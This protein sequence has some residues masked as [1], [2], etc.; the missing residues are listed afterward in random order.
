MELHQRLLLSLLVLAASA[1][2]AG[3]ARA[4]VPS[5]PSAAAASVTPPRLAQLERLQSQGARITAT[6]RFVLGDLKPADFAATGT[7]GREMSRKK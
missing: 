4:A 3:Q 1:A 7:F 6:G 2:G 5:A